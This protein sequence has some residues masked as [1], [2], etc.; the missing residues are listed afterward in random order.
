MPC[1][2]DSFREQHFFLSNFYRNAT[3]IAPDKFC[4][5]T[6]EHYFQCM[7]T[8]DPQAREL[9]RNAPSAGSSKSL[10]R[11]FQEITKRSDWIGEPAILRP[12]W[13]DIKVNVMISGVFMKFDQNW[14]VQE[15]LLK[16][17]DSI[18][19]EG[20]KWHDNFWGDCCCKKC[21]AIIGENMLGQIL[22]ILRQAF[23]NQ[24][25]V[26]SLKKKYERVY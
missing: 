6:V 2:I 26:E 9:I 7:K 12:D 24:E 20:N 11:K 1:V 5:P 22:M 21:K 16:T 19:V 23:Q 15:K 8:T 3:F 4:Y 14:N 13:E 25:D 10:G 18:L 17:N